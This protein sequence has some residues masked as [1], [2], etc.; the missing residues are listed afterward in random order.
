MLIKV[1]YALSHT[2]HTFNL[3]RNSLHLLKLVKHH[4]ISLVP[5]L[6]LLRTI[7]TYAFHPTE[8]CRGRAWYI[9]AHERHLQYALKKTSHERCDR[10]RSTS[11]LLPFNF[12]ST[13]VQLPCAL[14]R[15]VYSSSRSKICC[16]SERVVESCINYRGRQ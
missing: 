2:F 13:P 8:K 15:S 16:H 14:P 10:S 6:S 12:R 9:L 11:I 5:R 3:R 7:I 4:C 1:L